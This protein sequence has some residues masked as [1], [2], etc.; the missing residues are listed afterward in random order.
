MFEPVAVTFSTTTERPIADHRRA[1]LARRV[2]APPAIMAV[3]VEL[4]WPSRD[5]GPAAFRT[6]PLG[7]EVRAHG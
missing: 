7:T 5:G 3:L 1:A 2:S 6:T 4:A